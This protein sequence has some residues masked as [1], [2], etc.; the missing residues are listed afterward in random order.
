VPAVIRPAG[1][2]RRRVTIAVDITPKPSM[3]VYAPGNLAYA[4]VTLTIDAVT[5][6]TSGATN[7]PKPDEYVFAPLNERVKVYSAPFRLTREVTLA[8]RPGAAPASGTASGVVISGRLDYQACDDKVC[9]LP[10][11]LPLTWTVVQ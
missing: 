5:G 1:A 10:Q 9:Y 11:T 2:A 8:T 6:L 4:P 3:R 7:Y